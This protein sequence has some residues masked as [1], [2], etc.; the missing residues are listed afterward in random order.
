MIH[1]PL[2][3]ERGA[4][5]VS[6]KGVVTLTFGSDLQRHKIAKFG[7]FANMVRNKFQ[8]YLTVSKSERDVGSYSEEECRV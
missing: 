8:R 1:R 6:T 2:A 4:V 3:S 7:D 5:A